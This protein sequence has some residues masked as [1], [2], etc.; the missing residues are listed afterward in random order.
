MQKFTCCF[1]GH[2]TAKL[3]KSEKET[4]QLLDEAINKAINMGFKIFISGMATGIDTWAAEII[5]KKKESNNNIELLCAIPHPNFEKSRD[6][7]EKRLYSEIVSKANN[8]ILVN[9]H[10]FRGCYQVR[11]KW[12]VDMSSLVIAAFHHIEGGT[13]NTIDYAKKKN[14]EVINIFEQFQ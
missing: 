3:C 13:K 5:L 11:N 8:V 2:R 6:T 4:K 9:D 7:A 10:F 14:I 12:M 1:T